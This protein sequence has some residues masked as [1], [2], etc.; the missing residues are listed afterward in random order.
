VTQYKYFNKIHQQ[1]TIFF[2][3]SVLWKKYTLAIEERIAVIKKLSECELTYDLEGVIYARTT[4]L[5]DD[6]DL[7]LSIKDD[8]ATLTNKL[9]DDLKLGIN[10]KNV[11]VT[12]SKLDDCVSKILLTNSCVVARAKLFNYPIDWIFR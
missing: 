1:S 2:R 5:N 11:A 7:M 9:L 6:H 4:L 3:L 10:K 8:F 12:I